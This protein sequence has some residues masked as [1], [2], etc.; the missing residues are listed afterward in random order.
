MY[1]IEIAK[2]IADNIITPPLSAL[3]ASARLLLELVG[4]APGLVAVAA[5]PVTIELSPVGANNVYVLVQLG[6]FP[7][8]KDGVET[9]CPVFT[10]PPALVT[11]AVARKVE[12][13]EF[14]ADTEAMILDGTGAMVAWAEE[15]LEEYVDAPK[16][17]VSRLKAA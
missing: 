15:Q 9:D 4:F 1:R 5:A 11:V 8:L 16:S 14:Q 17:M 7:V 6:L 3:Q 12:Y 10:D 13:D 2:L